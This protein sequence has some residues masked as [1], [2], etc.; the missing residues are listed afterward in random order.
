MRQN[1]SGWLLMEDLKQKACD[2]LYFE[3]NT[4]GSMQIAIELPKKTSSI[5]I[6][7]LTNNR[8]WLIN[9]HYGN[10]R[11]DFE[12]KNNTVDILSGALSFDRISEDEIIINGKINIDSREPVTHQEIVFKSHKIKI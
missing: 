2:L 3:A 1:H 12:R 6:D 8:F 4:F 10:L 9:H 5:K 7:T 11:R